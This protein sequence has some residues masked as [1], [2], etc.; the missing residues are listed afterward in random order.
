MVIRA[1]KT[2][3]AIRQMLEADQGNLFRTLLKKHILNQEDAYRAVESP[4]RE[5]LGA[6]LI[7]R[8]CSRS[9]WMS[10]R[11][12]HRA[13]HSGRMIRLFNR[14]HLE[15]ARFVALLEMIGCTVYQVDENGKQ[16]KI[17]DHNGHYG[18]SLDGVVWGCPDIPEKYIISE[19]KTHNDKSFKKLLES[20]VRE[21]K[22]EHY[23][24]M[25][26]Y[27]GKNELE[28][29]LYLAVNK[30]D[31][32][33]YGEIIPFDKSTFRSDL[34]RACTIINDPSPPDR[35][36]NGPGFYKCRFC[37]HYSICQEQVAPDVNCRTCR[38]STPVKNGE[39][40]CESPHN[41]GPVKI[42]DAL[43]PCSH[44]TE[45]PEIRG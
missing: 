34:I 17:S 28:F 12:C 43:L 33:I 27:M 21:V 32:D 41:N 19:F 40:I 13:T 25:Q 44:Y 45:H 1:T 22:P 14:G 35:I 16:Y 36:Y 42:V 20:G 10:F 30:N 2:E 38:W 6:S 7:G 31:D 11:W 8:Q 37:D 39:W 3:E 26:Q 23:A 29:A 9:L 18:G 15:E 4:F 24:Q 5:H